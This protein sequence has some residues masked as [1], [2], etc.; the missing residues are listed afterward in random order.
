MRIPLVTGFLTPAR[1]AV[2][3]HDRMRTLYER[4]IL[5]PGAHDA[6]DGGAPAGQSSAT[7]TSSIAVTAQRVGAML[8]SLR[9]DARASP[10]STPL[11]VR[12]LPAEALTT[13]YGYL[14]Q[15]L[16]TAPRATVDPLLTLC[17][18]VVHLC[19]GSYRNDFMRLLL[20]LA[21]LV[22]R[23]EGFLVHVVALAQGS[24]QANSA[25]GAARGLWDTAAV[26]ACTDARGAA[27]DALARLRQFTTGALRAC[28][29]RHLAVADA[30]G[31][32]PALCMLHAHMVLILAHLPLQPSAAHGLAH[33]DVV[34][35]LWVSGAFVTAWHSNVPPPTAPQWLVRMRA[36]REAQRLQDLSPADQADLAAMTASPPPERLEF[37]EADGLT[38]TVP[39]EDVFRVL[40]V[41]WARGCRGPSAG[42]ALCL[43]A[44][45]TLLLFANCAWLCVWENGSGPPRRGGGMG[46][47]GTAGG[48]QLAA[49]QHGKHVAARHEPHEVVRLVTQRAR[50]GDMQGH[51]GE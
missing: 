24:E 4:I 23:V 41:R 35:G 36:M 28:L 45:L 3:F 43:C 17:R 25:R 13:R 15:E 14:F 26:K 19:T 21:R 44:G 37:L 50:H 1:L 2:L 27:T 49:D 51:C 38:P 32:V 9:G 18:K 5:E 16:S 48:R 20:Y 40:Q 30:A 33:V 46:S 31:D 11:V 22:H 42:V 8:E 7:P 34:Q 6:A 12:P 10:R 47:L 29:M 39:A